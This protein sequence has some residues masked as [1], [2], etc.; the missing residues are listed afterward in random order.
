MDFLGILITTGLILFCINYI[1]GWLL[2]FKV[3]KISAGT[4][5]IIFFLLMAN[6]VLVLLNVDF[7]TNKFLLYAASLLCLALIPLNINADKY[8]ITVSTISMTIFVFTMLNYQYFK[9]IA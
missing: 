7:P 6:L 9:I 1:I 4:H 5:R 2:K 3:I 8:H